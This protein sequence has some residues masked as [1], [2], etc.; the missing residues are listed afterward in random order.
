MVTKGLDIVSCSDDELLESITFQATGLYHKLYN[1]MELAGDDGFI[2]QMREQFPMMDASLYESTFVM[3]KATY[4]SLEEIRKSKEE[5]LCYIGKKLDSGVFST[6]Y[7]KTEKYFLEKKRMR[8]EKTKGRNITFGGKGSLRGITITKQ[9]IKSKSLELE[10]LLLWKPIG[11]KE[12]TEKQKMIDSLKK[13]I[14]ITEKLLE[15]YL[16]EYKKNR[17]SG[18]Y[19]VGRA[20]EGG[21]R[22]IDFDL[23]NNKAVFKINKKNRIELTFAPLRGK[24]FRRDIEKLQNA[25]DK[26]LIAVT[27]RITKTMIFLSYDEQKLEGYAFDTVGYKKEIKELG[28][29][30]QNDRKRIYMEFCKEQ[31]NRFFANKLKNRFAV[32]DKNPYEISVVIGDKLTNG[33]KFHTIYERVFDLTN[34]CKKLGL[35]SSDPRQIKQNNKRKTEI[36]EIWKYVFSLMSHFKVGNFI[37]EDLTIKPKTSAEKEFKEFNRQTKNVWHRSLTD[38]LIAKYTNKLGIKLIEV[39]PCYSSFIGNMNFSQYDPI[40]AAYELLRRG[41]VKYIKGRSFFPDT[42]RICLEKLD[43]LKSKNSETNSWVGMY[44]DIVHAGL[45][46][47]NRDKKLLWIEHYLNNKK[48]KVLIFASSVL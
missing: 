22:K 14:K 18:V 44:K 29:T 13:E 6:M 9:K 34:L 12:K 28:L 35:P 27:V 26:N 41:I 25:I 39:E 45:R 20:C 15:R 42:S 11:H 21:N 7:E 17:L 8:I 19:I 33:G 31:E 1:N 48:S 10:E 36:A 5:E 4:F 2:A 47:R 30:D 24:V 38:Q 23:L 46:Y 43:Y 32:V 3:A 40:A 16:A 37:Q